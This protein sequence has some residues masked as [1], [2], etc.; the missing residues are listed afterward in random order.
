M[1][2]SEILTLNQFYKIIC[3][4]L[5]IIKCL[6]LLSTCDVQQLLMYCL[7]RKVERSVTR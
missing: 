7:D 5:Y 4:Y 2:K 6:Y 1:L 3:I